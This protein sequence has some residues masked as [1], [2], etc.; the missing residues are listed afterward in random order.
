MLKISEDTLHEVFLKN[1][2]AYFAEHMLGMEIANHHV[3]WSELVAKHKKLSVLCARDHG[4]SYMFSFAYVIWRAYY[5]WIPPLPSK[6]FKSIPRQSLGYIFSSSQENAVKFLEMVKEEFMINPKLAHLVPA[7]K[8]VWSKMEIKLANNTIIRARGYGVAVRGGHPCFVVCDDVLTDENIYSEIQREKVKDYFYS[9]LTPM[10]IPGGQIVVVG[11]VRPDTM[12]LMK[13]GLHEIGEFADQLRIPMLTEFN[14]EVCGSYEFNNAEKFWINGKCKTIKIKTRYGLE[15]EGSGKHPIRVRSG[16]NWDW[17]KMS[18][19][20]KTDKVLVEIGQNIYGSSDLSEDEAYFMGLWIAEGSSENP[21]GLKFTQHQNKWRTQKKEFY[22]RSENKEIPNSV[23]RGTK[24]VQIAFLRGYFDGDGSSYVKDIA[25]SVI[26]SSVSYKLI[27]QVRYLLMN[28]GI[29]PSYHI[30][31][32][33]AKGN[34][35]CHKLVISSGYAFKFMN[36]IGFTVEHKIKKMED[37]PAKARL[38]VGINEI[39]DSECETVDFVIPKDHTFWSNGFISHNTPMQATDLYADLAEN[40]EYVSSH[41]SAI[42]EDGDAL[43]PTRYTLDMLRAREREIGSVRFAREYRCVPVSDASSLFPEKVLNENLHPEMEML[44]DVPRDLWDEYEV[45]TGVDL[46]LSASIGADY[47]VILT[48]GVDKHKNRRILDI[49]RHKGRSMT[50]QLR[51]IQ[52]VYYQYRPT[53]ILIEDNQFQRVFKDE[54]VTTTDLPVQGHTTT[55]QKNSFER[56]VPS[57]QIL[58]ENRKFQIPRKTDRCRRMTDVLLNELK[59]FTWA[60]G[61]LQGV[62]SHDDTVM[63]LWIANECATQ[64]SFSFSF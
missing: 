61:K 37:R 33:G 63:A 8:E 30:E 20:T 13:D 60:N 21:F 31:K 5:A 18:D 56:G 14:K 4:K 35:V 2:L 53:R 10:V 49:R 48:L 50:D 38:F 44:T 25:Q 23:L 40:Q 7:K 64:G 12:I 55:A 22:E 28:M 57:L 34:F 9:A 16:D 52:N 27:N 47:S 41:F 54:L 15:L 36:E 1:D 42:T 24:E 32:P 19:I 51:E 59:C 45:F 62:G 29:L 58:F 11:C 46:A 39:S 26:V 17:K 6:L 43:W 3:I